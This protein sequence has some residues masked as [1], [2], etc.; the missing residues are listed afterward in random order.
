MNAQVIQDALHGIL[1]NDW[2]VS[3]S[4]LADAESIQNYSDAGILTIS[5]GLV[6]KMKDGSEFQLTIV[7][8]N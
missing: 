7:Q 3:N 8:S 1:T 6:I 4:A 5:K 2:D